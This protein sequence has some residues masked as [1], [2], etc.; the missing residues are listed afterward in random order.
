VIRALIRDQR[1]W[2]ERFD[3]LL[4]DDYRVDGN[5]CFKTRFAPSYVTPGIVVYDVGG[6]KR[7]FFSTMEK[8]RL[9][10]K[11]IGV[12]ISADELSMAP[13]GAY[14]ETVCADVTTYR[15][16]GDG[17]LAVCCTLLEHVRDTEPAIACL[18]SLLREGGTALVFVPSRNALFARL[19]LL[20][21]ERAKRALL[22]GLFPEKREAQ[23]FPSYY[24]Q[25][26]PRRIQELGVAHGLELVK[27]EYYFK[28]SYFSFFLPFYV[29]WRGWVVASRALF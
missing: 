27:A 22:F 23:G 1:A 19:N 14:D 18:A 5:T 6:G 13:E 3:R 11:V 2:S 10:V 9:G 24:D 29:L 17:D 25:C 21:P 4:P 28:S 15:G 26:T 20:L 8:R 7:P 16:N 12:D